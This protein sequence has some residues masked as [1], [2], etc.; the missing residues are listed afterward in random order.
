MKFNLTLQ[1]K[2]FILVGLPL[3]CQ[4]LFITWS[5]HLLNETEREVKKQW[6]TRAVIDCCNTIMTEVYLSRGRFKSKGLPSPDQIRAI[7]NEIVPAINAKVGELLKLVEGSPAEYKAAELLK[8][9]CAEDIR[10]L[11]DLKREIR[12]DPSNIRLHLKQCSARLKQTTD[13]ISYTIGF[14]LETERR[15]DQTSPIIQ[16]RIREQSRKVLWFAVAANVFL[17]L[18]LASYFNRSAARRLDNVVDNARHMEEGKALNRPLTGSDEIAKVDEALHRAALSIAEARKKERFLLDNMPV[19]ILGIDETGLILSANPAAEEL[20]E[21]SAEQLINSNVA[22]LIDLTSKAELIPGSITE[23]KVLRPDRECWVELLVREFESFRLLAMIDISER[24]AIQRLRRQFVAMVSHDL[25]TPLTSVQASLDLIGAGCFGRL[26]EDGDEQIERAERSLDRLMKL[27]N[28]LLDSEKI[29]SG[30]FVIN[31]QYIS[32]SGVIDR[33][34]EGVRIISTKE[35]INIESQAFNVTCFADE[36]RIIQVMINLLGN[37]IKFSPKGST[38]SIATET[39][40]DIVKVSVIDQGRGIPDTML[41]QV[42]EKFMQVEK[43]DSQRGQG[44]GLGL[45][46]CKSII[47]QHD[48]NIGVESSEGH[49]STFWF[50]LPLHDRLHQDS[51]AGVG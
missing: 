21:E 39:P 16:S 36:D 1:Q 30:T 42:F 41:T 18:A 47:E 12:E 46:I 25:R 19:A 8:E 50:T 43:S 23:F 32:L 14:I 44:F 5:F 28:D 33:A 22:E 6:H 3:T 20:F 51:T 13:T 38:I 35:N 26:S 31:R 45:S 48:G 15:R 40:G 9:I 49:G 7:E 24:L 29:E 34:I 17:A 27:I 4:L 2:A 11:L 10:I 37:A